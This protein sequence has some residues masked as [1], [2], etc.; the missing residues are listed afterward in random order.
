MDVAT[1]FF[2]TVL[3]FEQFYT[4]G[5]LA[6]PSGTWCSTHFNIDARAVVKQLRLF[7]AF[8]INIELFE[9]DMPG[10][11]QVWP[12]M[13]DI[14]GWHLGFYVDDMDLALEYLQANGV[15][16]LGARRT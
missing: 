16:M 8:N 7:R 2:E 11:N 6:D 12:A 3:G 13:Q 5:P 4:M 14:G 15:R 10:Q 1:E 9:T